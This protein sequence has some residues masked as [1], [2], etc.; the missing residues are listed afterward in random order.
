MPGV[1]GA[2][3]FLHET[4]RPGRGTDDFSGIDETALERQNRPGS[5][6]PVVGAAPGMG[7]P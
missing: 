6:G 2:A 5:V 3:R 4:R 7:G 1:R